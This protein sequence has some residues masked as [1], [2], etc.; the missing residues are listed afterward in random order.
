MFCCWQVFPVHV[1]VVP[2]GWQMPDVLPTATKHAAPP[3]QSALV[4]HLPHAAEHD[5]PQTNVGDPDGFGMHG[6]PLQQSA[7][8]AHAAPAP[9]QVAP[10][11]RGTPTLSC[12][13]VMPPFCSQLPE[14][15]SQDAL[16]EVVASLQTSPFGL[17]PWGLLQIPSS[18]PAVFAHEPA[19]AS[20]QSASLWQVS[21]TKWHPLA[22]WQ[23]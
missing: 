11:Q 17:H 1:V 2:Q 20:Q 7:L 10:V 15:Q 12:L 4:V 16:Q 9:T 21:P 18:A 19:A 6:R 3:Q 23:I 8:E 14:Q 22:G 5:C 13:H